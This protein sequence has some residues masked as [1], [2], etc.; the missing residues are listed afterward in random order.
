MLLFAIAILGAIAASVLWAS[1]NSPHRVIRREQRQ[2]AR[3]H[4]LKVGASQDARVAAAFHEEATRHSTALGTVLKRMARRAQRGDPDAQAAL[5]VLER[6]EREL[7]ADIAW[8]QQFLVPK[9]GA[10]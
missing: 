1:R 4:F 9:G 10:T 6:M 8:A 5:V 7:V 3:E 2:S